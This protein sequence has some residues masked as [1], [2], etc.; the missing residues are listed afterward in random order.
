MNVMCAWCE[1]EGKETFIGELG[2]YDRLLISHGICH[3]HERLLAQ[4]IR[5]LRGR[6]NPKLL[7]RRPVCGAIRTSTGVRRTTSSRRASRRRML[8]HCMSTNQLALPFSPDTEE[9]RS[10]ETSAAAE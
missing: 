3:E 2:L 1:R 9:S 4:Q 5:E 6:D 8:T 10:V 7:R